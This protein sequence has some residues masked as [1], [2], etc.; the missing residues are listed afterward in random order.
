LT[1]LSAPDVVSTAATATA[2]AVA[3]AAAAAVVV[4]EAAIFGGL[5]APAACCTANF[6][7]DSV[8]N[9]FWIWRR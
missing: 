2:A 6:K 1:S 3:V 7:L 5:G 8:C 4:A 9:H